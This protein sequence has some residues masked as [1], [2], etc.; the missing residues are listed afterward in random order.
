MGGT[1]INCCSQSASPA[2]EAS[3]LA[4]C[5]QEQPGREITRSA[6]LVDLAK[7]RGTSRMLMSDRH[8]AEPSAITQLTQEVSGRVGRKQ[9]CGVGRKTPPRRVAANRHRSGKLV[10]PCLLAY[11]SSNRPSTRNL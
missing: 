3:W 9:A 1:K 5:G 2:A 10:V 8:S 7:V 11:V 6:V 4:A